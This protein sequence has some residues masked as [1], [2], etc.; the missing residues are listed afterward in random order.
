M[1]T[2]PKNPLLPCHTNFVPHSYLST[3]GTLFVPNNKLTDKRRA[4]IIAFTHNLDKQVRIYHKRV[5]VCLL[6]QFVWQIGPQSL[7][8]SLSEGSL[9]FVRALFALRINDR[10]LFSP[11]LK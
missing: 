5:K 11:F 6:L 7:V 3:F 2:G 8:R 1:D 4:T 10:L 9:S